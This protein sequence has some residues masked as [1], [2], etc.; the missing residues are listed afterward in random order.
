MAGLKRELLKMPH[1]GLVDLVVRLCK[2]QE[3]ARLYVTAQLGGSTVL[4]P[5]LGKQ[6]AVME[7]FFFPPNMRGKLRL[8]DAKKLINDFGKLSPTTEQLVDLML[9]YVELG[10]A[11]TNEFGDIDGSF[12]DSLVGMYRDVID[13]LTAEGN[14]ALTRRFQPRLEAVVNDSSDIGWG[15]HN[16]LSEAY[17]Q[18]ISEYM[19]SGE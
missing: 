11:C 19:V 4:E 14:H 18:F 7:K 9:H 2:Q 13:R 17:H 6:K 8:S 16:D 1:T 5:V 15:F 3:S 10:V 12:Y